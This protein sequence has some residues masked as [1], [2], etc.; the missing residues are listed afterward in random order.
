MRAAHFFIAAIF[1]FS[2][3]TFSFA[4]LVTD[5]RADDSE[6]S[7]YTPAKQAFIMDFNSGM[8]LLNKNA[9]ERMPTSSMSKVMTMY[10]VFDALDDGRITLNDTFRVSEKAWRKGGSKMFVEV[11]DDVKV[12]DLIRGVIIQSGNDATIVL[13]EALA[14]NEDKFAEIM[15]EKAQEIGAANS[16]FVNASGWPAPDHYSNARDLATIAGAMIRNFDAYFHYYSETEFTY[17]DITQRNRNPLLYQ[18]IGADG[19]KTGHTKAAGYGLIGTGKRDGRRVIMVINGLDSVSERAKEARRLM[20][21][22]LRSFTNKTLFSEQDIVQTVPV[23]MGTEKEIDMVV[24]EDILVTV[25]KGQEDDI[26]VEAEYIAPL[27][28]PIKKGD[29][30]GQLTVKVPETGTIKAPLMAGQSSEELG[31]F[32][33]VIAKAKLMIIGGPGS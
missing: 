28:A 30:I 3:I 5:A 21:W 33:K 22:A 6:P 13:A 18:N 14:A 8:T 27:K 25:P 32:G 7:R 1:F 16:N 24:S 23:V 17:N 26:T 11:G 19:M 15:T 4:I 20:S 29:L 10:M 2:S 12:E 9:D 31:F